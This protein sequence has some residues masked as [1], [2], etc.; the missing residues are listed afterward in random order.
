VP[1][2]CLFV[3]TDIRASFFA[4]WRHLVLRRDPV[5]EQGLRCFADP[6]FLRVAEE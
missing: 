6:G 4:F 1:F 2:E 3:S 5:V